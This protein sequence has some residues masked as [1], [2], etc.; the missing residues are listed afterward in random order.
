MTLD[1]N[2]II[3]LDFKLFKNNELIANIEDLVVNI[4]KSNVE[5]NLLEIVADKQIFKLEL[6]LKK[7]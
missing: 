7:K 5:S 3:I 2:N 4:K 1:S 6:T